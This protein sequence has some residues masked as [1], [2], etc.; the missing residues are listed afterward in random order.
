MSKHKILSF[1][2]EIITKFHNKLLER[3]NG[4]D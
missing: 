4:R 1:D 2:D 3:H